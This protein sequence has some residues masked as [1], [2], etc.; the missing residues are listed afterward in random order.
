MEQSVTDRC[1]TPLGITARG[2]DLLRQRHQGRGVLNAS[3]HH[4]KGDTSYPWCGKL[5]VVLNA[6]R[7]HGKGDGEIVGI[8]NSV[9]WVL[10]ASRHHGKGDCPRTPG[11]L[12]SSSAQR[13]SASRQGGR[14]SSW[15]TPT[16]F[17]AQR[18]S[19]SRQGGL[20]APERGSRLERVLNAS[21]HHGKGDLWESRT[22][23]SCQPKC[24]TPLGITARGTHVKPGLSMTLPSAQRLSASRQGGRRKSV[25]NAT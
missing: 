3:R 24:S 1:S 5:D 19:A 18:L 7:H 9:D 11:S 13:L 8:Y 14:A 22:P 17:S 16:P 6:S 2:T 12:P 21:R 23:L 15:P 4:G 10:N 25:L 20:A